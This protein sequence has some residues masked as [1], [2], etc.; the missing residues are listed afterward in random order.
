[1]VGVMGECEGSV[2]VFV[3]GLGG[4]V[5]GWG[6]RCIGVGVIFY[7]LVISGFFGAVGF[8]FK[9]LFM[10]FGFFFLGEFYTDV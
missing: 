7:F 1:M 10:S 8:S 2:C 4:R 6:A 5:E 3:F 9:N